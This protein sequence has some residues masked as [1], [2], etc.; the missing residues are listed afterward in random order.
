MTSQYFIYLVWHRAWA[1]KKC[2]QELCTLLRVAHGNIA[3]PWAF[4]NK[5]AIVMVARPNILYSWNQSEQN[6][7]NRAFMLLFTFK[8]QLLQN[9]HQHHAQFYPPQ[10]VHQQQPPLLQYQQPHRCPAAMLLPTHNCP[11]AA[12]AA[13]CGPS[14]SLIYSPQQVSAATV[15]SSNVSLQGNLHRDLNMIAGEFQ[16]QYWTDE[17]RLLLPL[18]FLQHGSLTAN[19]L[20]N[21]GCKV[22]LHTTKLGEHPWKSCCTI[23]VH[24]NLLS[25]STCDRN[26]QLQIFATMWACLLHTI[27]IHDLSTSSVKGLLVSNVF[28]F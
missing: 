19:Q 21:Q 23:I 2:T 5:L 12:A 8:Q 4:L 17:P 25:I 27:L 1:W 18:S 26:L 16:V 11:A 7:L 10:H 24:N 6:E 15:P 20:K 22:V 14:A 28:T 13:A 9:Q 3:Q